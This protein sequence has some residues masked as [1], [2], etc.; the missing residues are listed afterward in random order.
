MRNCDKSVT[1]KSIIS[2]GDL[3]PSDLIKRLRSMQGTYMPNMKEI[4]KELKVLWET[5]EEGQT[6]NYMLRRNCISGA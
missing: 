6:G 2:L 4:G 1:E 5:S 3:D